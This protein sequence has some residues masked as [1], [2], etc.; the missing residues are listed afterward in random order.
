MQSKTILGAFS[1]SFLEQAGS[2][3][4]A[5]V[6]QIALARILV[7][8]DFGI[9]AILLVVVNIADVIAQSGFGMALIQRTDVDDSSYTTTFWI[10]VGISI[11]I[12]ILLWF[13]APV[14]QVFYRLDGLASYLRIISIVVIF[15]AFNAIQ[16]SYLQRR[17][18]FKSLFRVSLVAT[19]ASGAIGIACALYG[20]GVWALVAQTILQSAISCAGLL[21]VV[22]WK[23]RLLF[24]KGQAKSL[25]SY[26]WKLSVTGILNVLYTGLSEL[27]IGRACSPADLG[28]Y[29]QGRKYP[30]AVIMVL[31]NSIQNVIFPALS[32]A[33]QNHQE[34]MH[35]M[36]QMLILGT[37]VIAPISFLFAVAAEPVVAIVL[38]EKWLPCV[39]IFQMACLSNAVIILQIANLRAYMALGHSGLYLKLNF[40]KCIAGAFVICSVSI[41]TRDVNVVAATVCVF[42]F[43]AV[44]FVDLHPAKRL[45]DFGWLKQLENVFP[46]YVLCIVSSI[47][48][49]LINL[50]DWP[51]GAKLVA[52]IVVFAGVYV[53]CAKIARRP[54]LHQSREIIR[55]LIKR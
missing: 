43:G 51:Y 9:L 12:L 7:P 3:A 37:F 34:F 30:N 27:V 55:R 13:I 25:F 50:I 16:R 21:V 28:Y 35:K 39:F 10:S 45:L 44:I 52:Q 11:S 1:W 15:N 24:N 8:E 40:I 4:V 47:P 42:S 20:M 53:G 14:L 26:G 49:Y 5:L 23:P 18:D 31:T 41:I 54:E 17:M 19:I 46:T 33:K 22:P 6:V 29:S 2:K 36:K 48:A 32:L 38:T